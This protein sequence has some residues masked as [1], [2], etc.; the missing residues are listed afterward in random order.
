MT[1]TISGIQRQVNTDWRQWT[2]EKFISELNLN[3]PVS[4]RGFPLDKQALD[5]CDVCVCVLP[6]GRSAHLEAGYA[7]GRGKKVIFC[8]HPDKFEPELMYLLGDGCVV[9]TRELASALEK[10]ARAE[11]QS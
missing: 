7:A 2:P 8:L 3:N 6:C 1:S 10:L 11:K 9:T 5:D 4:A